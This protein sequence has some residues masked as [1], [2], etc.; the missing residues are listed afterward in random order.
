MVV[1]TP[2]W[3]YVMPGLPELTSTLGTVGRRRFTEPDRSLAP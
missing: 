2:S 1:V 3:P